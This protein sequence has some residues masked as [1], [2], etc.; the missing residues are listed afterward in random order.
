MTITQRILCC[1]GN[2][3]ARPMVYVLRG[4]QGD[5]LIDT[6]MEECLN[7]I[8]SWIEE[9]G[10]TIKW[11]FLTHGHFDHVWN[12]PYFREKYGAKVLMHEKDKSLLYECD[13]VPLKASSEST[14]Y[15][16]ACANDLVI[17]HPVKSCNIDYFITDKDVDYLRKIG[18]DADIVMLP[19]HTEG[20]IGIQQ[21]RVMYCGDAVSA[22]GGDYFTAMFGEN[23]GSIYLSEKKIFEMNPL[24]I[25]PGHGKYIINEKAFPGQETAN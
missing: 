10:F 11:I 4:K 5:M 21:G 22:K 14:E 17:K 6:G 1:T 20:S 16:T 18:F 19:G 3:A 9:N 23:V 13:R 8:D 12:A 2:I 15:E 7:Q 25:A 24:I